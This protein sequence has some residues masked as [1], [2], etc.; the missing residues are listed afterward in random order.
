MGGNITRFGREANFWV[1]QYGPSGNYGGQ[2]EANVHAPTKDVET[3]GGSPTDTPCGY[4]SFS[5]TSV[6]LQDTSG[7][8]LRRSAYTSDEL[9]LRACKEQCNADA[10]C[11]GFVDDPTDTRGRMCKPKTAR[12]GYWRTGKTFYQKGGGC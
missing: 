12:S 8:K 9:Y 7:A 4:V 6:L 10:I 2:F 5:N 3:C 11:R 1:C